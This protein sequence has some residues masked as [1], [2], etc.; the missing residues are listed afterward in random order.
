MK[1]PKTETLRKKAFK[2]NRRAF[3]KSVIG[4]IKSLNKE[5]ERGAK[6][7]LTSYSRSFDDIKGGWGVFLLFRWYR[8]FSKL[9][10]K[11]E[12]KAST[13]QNR[14]YIEEIHVYINWE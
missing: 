3:R 6:R 4:Y 12:E 11:I 13:I 5:L 7:G 10:V 1:T 9:N 2:Y 14:R 8:R